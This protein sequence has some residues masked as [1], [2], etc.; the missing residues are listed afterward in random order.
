MKFLGSIKTQ[1][2]KDRVK[3]TE[4]EDR[5]QIADLVT[6]ER[7]IERQGPHGMAEA[8]VFHGLKGRDPVE[9]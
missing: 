2:V 1:C 3:E 6:L 4:W 5:Q 8:M 7:I 9:F